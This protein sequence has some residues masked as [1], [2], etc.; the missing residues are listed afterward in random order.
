VTFFRRNLEI[1]KRIGLPLFV[2]TLV[3]T[4]IDQLLTINIDE[5]LRTPTG[6]MGLVWTLGFISLVLGILFPILGILVVIYG[7]GHPDSNERGL[8]RYIRKFL[9]QVSIEILRSWGKTLLWSLLL[10]LPGLWK[11]IQ[12]TLIPFVVTLSPSYAAGDRDALAYSAMV[13]RHHLGKVL[14]IIFVFHLFIPSIMTVFFDDERLVWITPVPALLL[15]VVDVYFF[16]LSTQLLLTVFEH[17]GTEP[18][19][20]LTLTPPT[21]P[22]ITNESAYI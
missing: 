11:Y 6:G 18:A 17:D 19:V 21:P 3:Y 5:T 8:F 1:F 14:A 10:I 2:L 9:N 4:S 22:E 15:T 13:V 7:A 16:I 20:A 12:Y